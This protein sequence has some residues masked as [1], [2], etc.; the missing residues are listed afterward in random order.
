ML[1]SVALIAEDQKIIG[2]LTSN[3]LIGQMMNLQARCI[4]LEFLDFLIGHG[5]EMPPFT[6]WQLATSLGGIERPIA[7]F[8]PFIRSKISVI[9]IPAHDVYS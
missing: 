2:Q 1:R 5:P 6:S 8:L 3:P 9:F 4:R 7:L